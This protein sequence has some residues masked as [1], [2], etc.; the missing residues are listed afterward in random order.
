M[1]VEK[2]NAICYPVSQWDKAKRFYGDALGLRL[3]F[4]DDVAGLV[5]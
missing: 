1:R 3:D 4:I 5:A 2:I